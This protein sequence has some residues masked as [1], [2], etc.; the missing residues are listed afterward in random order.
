MAIS[1]NDSEYMAEICKDLSTSLQTR[2]GRIA[3]EA[4]D[5]VLQVCDQLYL[6]NKITE[7]QLLYLR[8]LVLI[9]DES[10][11]QIY[12]DFQDHQNVAMLAKALYDHSNTHPFMLAQQEEEEAEDEEED[13][14]DDEEENTKLKDT[15]FRRSPKESLTGAV[16]LMIRSKVVTNA[17]ANVL[18]EMIRGQNEYVMAAYELYESDDNLE[19]LQDTLLRCAKLEIRKRLAD[20]KEAQLSEQEKAVLNR[21]ED[22]NESSG[23]DSNGGSESDDEHEDDSDQDEGLEDETEANFSLEDIGLDTIMESLRVENIWKNSVPEKFLLI[24]FVAVIQRHLEVGQA[25]ALCDLYQAEYDL[26]RA[27]WEVYTV[28]SDVIDFIDT[29]KRVVRDLDFDRNGDV[30]MTDRDRRTNQSKREDSEEESDEDSGEN[31]EEDDEE[32]DEDREEEI[33]NVKSSTA[34]DEA[35]KIDRRN[36]ALAAVASAKKELLKHS[37]EM[38][39]KQG[40]TSAEDASNL[41]AR[42]L[43]GDMM[44]EAA[45]D[46][47]AADRE[48][49]EFLTTLRILSSHTTE[50]LQEMMKQASSGESPKKTNASASTSTNSPGSPY[51]SSDSTQL[52][53]RGIVAELSRNKMIDVNLA[54]QLLHLINNK[55]NRVMAAYG[56]YTQKKDGAQLIDS[57]LKIGA[58]ENSS[59]N[60]DEDNEDDDEDDDDE[61]EN[62]SDDNADETS[63]NQSSDRPTLLNASDQK[64]VVEIL[65]RYR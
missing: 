45:I 56:E 7:N 10:V 13:D 60:Q 40:M 58:G 2:E 4:Q 17:E 61:D 62:E 57:L 37:L 53:L 52:Q 54:A 30:A 9:R 33:T 36:E 6:S 3:C 32:K 47:Y 34:S 1:A 11:A 16:A 26:V 49:A 5:E 15:D 44:I 35:T 51:S 22:T 65:S 12:D 55:D 48:V 42:Y 50:E 64:T 24:V 46:S 27:A 25:K 8:H 19:E 63:G 31:D 28:Q 41:Y 23:S 29:L 21:N 18:I 14:D 43:S 39:V 20:Q 38:M 59:V